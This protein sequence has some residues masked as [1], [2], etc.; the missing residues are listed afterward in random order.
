MVLL[1]IKQQK[2]NYQWASIHF[3][4]MIN[5]HTEHSSVDMWPYFY[6]NNA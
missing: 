1:S 4:Y 2:L 5:S 3:P 6:V